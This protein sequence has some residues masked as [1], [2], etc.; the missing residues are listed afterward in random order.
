MQQTDFQRFKSMLIGVADC[1]GQTLTAE[2]IAM[3]FKL[4]ERY[5]FT[6]VE[7]AALAILSTRK[8]SG[9]PTPGDFI[10]HLSGGCVEDL[11]EVEAGK[12]IMAVGQWG[13]YR[14]VVFDDAVTQAVIMNA[15]GGWVK[16]CEDCGAADSEKWFRKEFAKT[17]AAY[18]RQGVE[19]YGVLAG[20][21]EIENTARGYLKFVEPPTLIGNPDKAR[22]VALGA[23]PGA[24]PALRENDGEPAQIGE[25]MRALPL[26]EVIEAEQ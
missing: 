20:L 1:Y 5:E 2:G 24:R 26:L 8:Y 22:A 11:A 18:R 23:K 3:R 17:Y 19:Y 13:G 12:V 7:R 10:E 15:Y 6:E 14:S 25:A 16:L 9:M 21:T 4:L